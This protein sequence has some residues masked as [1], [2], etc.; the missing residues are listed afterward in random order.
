MKPQ[1]Q[2]IKYARK[3]L[4][5]I[6]KHDHFMLSGHINA[7]GD[8]IAAVL[9]MQMFLEKMGK[10]AYAIFS[11]K[12]LDHRFDYLRNFNRIVNYDPEKG[13][14]KKIESAI[15][16]DVPGYKRLGNVARLL[17]PAQ[18]VVKV[19]HHPCEDVLGH[20]DWVDEEAS[21]TTAMIF[22]ILDQS[23]MEIDLD[24]AKA[25]FTGIVY[26]TGR[27]S[28]SN[29]TARDY[30]IAAQMVDIGVKPSEITNRVFFENSFTALKTI[31]KGLASLENYLD[32]AVNVI[33]LD[34]N[35]MSKNDQSEIEELANYSVAIRGGEVGLFIR[36]IKPGFHKVSFR[37]RGKVDVNA[38]AKAFDGGGHSRAAGC[39]IEGNKKE[40]LPRILEEIRKQLVEK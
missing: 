7:D 26:D 2:H 3:I 39:R 36:E 33:Y 18:R 5:F 40:I 27:F 12:K 9:A 21:S 20:I 16:L 29:T 38:V 15:I 8:A 10:T 23:A 31:G 13:F 19:D 32:G 17:P 37:S 28:F 34:A 14:D 24:L 22:E 11:D 4:N 35:D 6:E 1:E 30:Y 25:V